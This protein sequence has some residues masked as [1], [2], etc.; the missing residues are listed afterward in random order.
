M[1]DTTESLSRPD[2]RRLYAYIWAVVII[3]ALPIEL[4]AGQRLNMPIYFMLSSFVLASMA[5]SFGRNAG[6]LL[7]GPS[8]VLFAYAIFLLATTAWSYVGWESAAYAAPIILM[9]LVSVPLARI[10]VDETVRAIVKVAVLVSIVGWVVGLLEP[11]IGAYVG[12]GWRL[13]GIMV[14][15]QRMSLFVALAII[16]LFNSRQNGTLIYNRASVDLMALLFLGATLLATQT[17]AFTT[18]AA[19][20]LVFMVIRRWGG[21]TRI[22]GMITLATGAFVAAPFLDSVTGVVSVYNREGVNTETLSGRTTIWVKTLALAWD[23]WEG[24]HGFGSFFTD[25]TAGFFTNYAPPHAHNDLIN[26]FFESGVVGVGLLVI[27]LS[28]SILRTIFSRSSYGAPVLLFL[29]ICGITGV[30]F[31]GKI[32]TPMAIGVVILFQEQFAR[33]RN[34]VTLRAARIARVGRLSHHIK[35]PA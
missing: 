23:R 3:E 13:N 7:S 31:G 28:W 24:G 4:G 6:M 30:V 35:V 20:V 10:P 2:R 26:A 9:V 18:Y 17:R 27:F 1:S 12:P 32:G 29:I 14:H 22:I 19:L 33:H 5:K 8:G 11:S 21:R 34:R 25:L 16:M 15:C